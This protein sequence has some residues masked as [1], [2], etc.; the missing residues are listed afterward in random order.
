MASSGN[1][2]EEVWMEYIKKNQVRP[3]PENN[4]RVTG[5]RQTADQSG[6]KP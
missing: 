4:F 1:V 3:E 5:V 6:F 2:I